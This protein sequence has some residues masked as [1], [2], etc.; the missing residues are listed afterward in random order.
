MPGELVAPAAIPIP[1]TRV[2]PS[3][4][5]GPVPKP[6]PDPNVNP[7]ARWMPKM[8]PEPDAEP[9]PAPED[10]ILPVPKLIAPVVIPATRV[11]DLDKTLMEPSPF[12]AA[13]PSEPALSAEA[14]DASETVAPASA[15]GSVPTLPGFADDE[16]MELAR[17]AR[18][19]T[20]PGGES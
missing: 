8:D 9:G 11:G 6:V 2:G 14:P 1:D 3:R 19:A 4:F 17:K 16:A 10:E 15:E 7:D 20:K 5:R 12:G 13:P 18:E